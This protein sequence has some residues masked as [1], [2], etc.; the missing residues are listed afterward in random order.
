MNTK[1]DL[2]NPRTL[3]T[4]AVMTALVLSLTFVHIAQTPIGGYIHLGDIAIYFASF[5][6]GPWIGMVAGGLGTGLADVLSGYAVY[7]PL[8]LIAHGLQGFVAGWIFRSARTQS[9]KE[10]L[11]LIFGVIA[12]SIILVAGYFLGESLIPI[13]GGMAYAATEIPWN[14]VQEAVGATGGA[15]YLAVARAYPRL[16]QSNQ[17]PP[18]EV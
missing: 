3:A 2:N 16:N 10:G 5:A 9:L 8:S 13:F 7:S 4:T 17:Q 1:F 11:R 12:G 15:V 18:A 6:F 14:F